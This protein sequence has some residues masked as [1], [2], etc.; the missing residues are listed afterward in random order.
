MQGVCQA[1]R[2]QKRRGT[3]R[4]MSAFLACTAGLTVL[5]AVRATAQIHGIPPSVTSIGGHFLPNP[6]ASVTSLGPY[7]FGHKP[8]TGITPTWPYNGYYH[9]RGRGYGSGGYTYAVPYYIPMDGFG[10]DYVS[11]P[12]MYSGPPLYPNDQTLHI[13]VEQ[14]PLKRYGSDSEYAQAPEPARPMPGPTTEIKPIEPTV[15]VFRDGHQQEVTDY[16]IMGQTVYVFDKGMR[17]I[18]FADLDLSATVKAN[19]DRGVE[20]RVPAQKPAPKKNTGMQ[21]KSTPEADA[22]SPSSIASVMP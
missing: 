3:S 21:P 10:Y 16:A 14:A 2:Q 8:F 4:L 19:D 18:A 20:F 17:K 13:V 22:P 7:G 12:E 15:L 1:E 9:R 5:L 11:G 6:P